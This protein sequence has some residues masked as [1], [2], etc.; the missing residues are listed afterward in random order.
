MLAAEAGRSASHCTAARPRGGSTT[1]LLKTYF[2]GKAALSD[3]KSTFGF[4]PPTITSCA[5]MPAFAMG[6]PVMTDAT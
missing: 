1:V 3:R 6:S 5:L 2:R 4:V